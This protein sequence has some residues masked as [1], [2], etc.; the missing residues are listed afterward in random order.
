MAGK[1]RHWPTKWNKCAEISS[2]LVFV[3][4]GGL[5]SYFCNVLS[6]LLALDS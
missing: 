4:L 3:G 5:V 6:R 2:A 1:R